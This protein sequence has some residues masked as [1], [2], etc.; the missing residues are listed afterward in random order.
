MNE[1]IIKPNKKEEKD[2]KV[3]LS[4]KAGA[5]FMLLVIVVLC[6]RCCPKCDDK[7]PEANITSASGDPVADFVEA[8]G[9]AAINEPDSFNW[10]VFCLVCQTASCQS[11]VAGGHQTNDAI[12]ETWA[13]DEL[14]FPDSPA[15]QKDVPKWPIC[16]GNKGPKRQIKHLRKSKQQEIFRHISHNQNLALVVNGGNE[17]VRRNKSSFDF[18]IQNKLWYVEGCKEYYSKAT[19]GE[20][21]TFMRFPKGA[22]EVKAVWTPIKETD[23]NKYHWNYDD[24]GHLYGL[25]G[26]HIMTKAIPNWTWATWEWEDNPGRCDYMG[27]HDS[28]GV[29]PHNVASKCTDP[30]QTHCGPPYPSGEMSSALKEMFKKF[31]LK[32]DWTHYRLKGSQTDW[33]DAT[34]RIINV[35]NSVTENG[36]IGSS[37]CITCHSVASFNNTGA[38]N[39]SI[40]FTPV[41][42]NVK[43]KPDTVQFSQEGP[44]NDT[45]FW[46]NGVPVTGKPTYLPMDFVWAIFNAHNLPK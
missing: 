19:E 4:K 29:V 35:G 33:I 5:I 1:N 44:V 25:V 34:G 37:S 43:G 2:F 41:V 45:N 20:K 23:K 16:D 26:L 39:P 11:E 40:G 9:S 27:C 46:K 31:G 18:I 22:V 24:S 7:K 3:Q 32:D 28:F 30:L 15:T 14:T 42:V 13:T 6:Y 10:A 36:F 12:W 8:N 17:E 38:V 21:T